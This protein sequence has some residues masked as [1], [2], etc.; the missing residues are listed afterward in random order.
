MGTLS[1]EARPAATHVRPFLLS[2]R[3]LAL[4]GVQ[5]FFALAT[6]LF[7]ATVWTLGKAGAVLKALANGRITGPLLAPFLDLAADFVTYNRGI[8]ATVFVAPASIA[9]DAVEALRD[10]MFDLQMPP[11]GDATLRKQ[12]HAARVANVQRQIRELVAAGATRLCTARP[13]FLAM[14]MKAG[15]YK[16]HWGG[17]EVH[18]LRDI[19]EIDEEREVVRVEPGC[20][21]GRLSRELIKKGWSLQVL[22]ELD[23]LTVGG[24]ING[25]GIETSSHKYGLFQH[26][27]TAF[28]IVLPN[29]DVVYCDKDHE[30]DLFATIPWSH[31]TIGFLVAA[32]IKLIR[33]KPY[34][35][36]E[37]IPCHTQQECVEVFERASRDNGNDFVEELMYSKEMGV[38]MIGKLASSVPKGATLN[39][40]SRWYKPWF[41]THVASFLKRPAGAPHAVE[42]LPLRDYY[43]R[44]TRSIFWEIQDIVPSGN[45]WWYR[46]FIAWIGTPKIS[47]LKMTTTGKLKVLWETKH[48]AQDL[49]VPISTLKESLDLF[50]DELEVYPLWLCP[51]RMLSPPK[52]L[53]AER[54]E[55]PAVAVLN[56][57]EP[58]YPPQ[59]VTTP[60]GSLTPPP[61]AEQLFVDV[62]AYGVPKSQKF[63]YERSLQVIEK[64]VRGVQGYQA[65]YA[66]TMMSR[67]EFR[68]MFDHQLYDKVRERFNCGERL[69]EIWDKVNKNARA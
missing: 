53:L 57:D 41:F 52:N 5:T 64:F 58:A 56:S 49:L 50:H 12:I 48:V 24:L 1:K 29:G 25:F 22:P 30:P 10:W 6:P 59:E 61:P 45:S 26:T 18:A 37:Y 9:W 42:Y 39:V 20:N 14:S 62:G 8:F 40:L 63:H 2:P 32:E 16:K 3:G 23:D 31:G 36:I 54:G 21:M 47:I 4:L 17:V 19:I 51:M 46:Y 13:G 66:D 67:G 33:A 34:V 27:C 35:Q 68:E 55:A 7:G 43:H 65:L 28:E 60:T 38:V 69:P 15:I 11:V 44:H